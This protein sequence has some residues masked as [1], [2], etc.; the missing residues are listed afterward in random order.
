MPRPRRAPRRQNGQSQARAHLSCC[1]WRGEASEG[2]ASQGALLLALPGARP[3]L[4]FRATGCDA[5]LIRCTDTF[6]HD[7][8]GIARSRHALVSLPACSMRRLELFSRAPSR[9]SSDMR[10]LQNTN[11]QGEGRD[12]AANMTELQCEWWASELASDHHFNIISASS[13]PTPRSG[14]CDVAS[15]PRP[16]RAGS[17]QASCAGSSAHKGLE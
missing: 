13:G 15:P 3:S 5:S 10:G 16:W 8:I 4:Q 17:E 12:E 7:C 2:C 6:V 9:K 1:D 14:A 11:A